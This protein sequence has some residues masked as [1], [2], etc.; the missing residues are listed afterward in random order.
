MNHSEAEPSWNFPTGEG[1]AEATDACG[2]AGARRQ[3]GPG[4]RR[5]GGGQRDRR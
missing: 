1:A 5:R 4:R 2:G 3:G